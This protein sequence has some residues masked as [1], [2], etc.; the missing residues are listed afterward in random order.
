[1]SMSI[2]GGETK[3][4]TK[5][6]MIMVC[7][8]FCVLDKNFYVFDVFWTIVQLSCVFFVVDVVVVVFVVCQS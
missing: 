2:N 7:E 8:K 4:L 1:M 3:L 6:F 5:S